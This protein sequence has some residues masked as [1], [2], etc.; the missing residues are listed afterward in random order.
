VVEAVRLGGIVEGT[1][2]VV[3][4]VEVAILGIELHVAADEQI[5]AAVAIVV[6]PGRADRPAV[7]FDASLF[8]DVFERAVAAVAIENRSSVAGDEQIDKAVVV[9][10]G[11][12]R[13][14]AV[15]V[16]RR[17]RPVR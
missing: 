11:R 6:Q 4:G 3:G 1:G 16:R 10:V 17:H 13:R 14:R 7:D 15:N 12:D 8:R 5:D 2:I 9:E